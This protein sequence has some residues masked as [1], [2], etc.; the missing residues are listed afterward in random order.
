MT[1]P[2]TSARTGL[3]AFC[4]RMARASPSVF[5]PMTAEPTTKTRVSL[6][7]LRK[8][9]SLKARVK[10]S[11]PMKRAPEAPVSCMSVNA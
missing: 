1:T 11:R 5:W 6:T 4:I 8:S 7:A 9:L 10:L 2:L 3:V